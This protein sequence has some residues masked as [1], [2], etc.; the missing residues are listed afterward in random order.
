M[1]W[2]ALLVFVISNVSLASPWTVIRTEVISPEVSTESLLEFPLHLVVEEGSGWNEAGVIPGILRKNSQIFRACGL[3]VG[4][5]SLE[6][7]RLSPEALHALKNPNPYKGPGEL[8]LVPGITTEVRPLVFLM[9]RSTVNTASAFNLDSVTRLSTPTVD[10]RGLLNTSVISDNHIRP[11]TTTDYVSSYDTFAHEL[12]HI[13]GNM[14]HIPT[15][16]NLMSSLEGRG[17]KSGGLTTDQCDQIL[18]F[19][20]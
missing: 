1:R 5:A 19:F 18:K 11:P 17:A 13:F 10:A 2:I 16:G 7:V 4:E 9:K 6:V 8:V 20:R 15:Q 14:G 3:K 12:A